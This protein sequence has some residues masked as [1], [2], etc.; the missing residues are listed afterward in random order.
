MNFD[1]ANKN[2]NFKISSWNV[3]GLRA[4]LKKDGLKYIIAEEP[5]VLC[6]QET[7]CQEGDLPPEV[8][9]L[10]N[11]KKYWC[12]SKKKGYAGV[13]LF[14][15]T[16]PLSVEMGIEDEEHDEEG[17]CITAEYDKFYVVSVYVTNAGTN[18]QN[19]IRITDLNFTLNGF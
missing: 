17:R 3:D 13:A 1:H 9:E 16:P 8:V 18:H 12:N 2:V 14:S 15:K 7:K 5:D 19:A 10:P 4:W 6:L 11:Y